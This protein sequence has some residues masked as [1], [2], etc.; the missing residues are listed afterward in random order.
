MS[1]K[2]I[3]YEQYEIVQYGHKDDLYIMVYE[4][5]KNFRRIVKE[6]DYPTEVK[7]IINGLK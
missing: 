6:K 4:N 7:K 1:E 5:G 3:K 2:V